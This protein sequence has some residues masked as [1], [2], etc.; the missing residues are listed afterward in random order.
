M[1]TITVRKRF[2]AATVKSR[3]SA[4][5]IERALRIAGKGAKVVFPIDGESFF[6]SHKASGNASSK[7]AAA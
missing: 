6:S 3:V 2:G 4:P 1:I 5:S 7:E